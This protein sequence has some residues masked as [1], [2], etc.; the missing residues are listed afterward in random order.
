[1]VGVVE[2]N[3]L[4]LASSGRTWFWQLL[5]QNS[6]FRLTPLQENG[7]VSSLSLNVGV[8]FG[9]FFVL[10]LAIALIWDS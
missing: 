7:W 2:M 1:M 4:L 9:F 3:A 6:H 10:S 8:H 5:V